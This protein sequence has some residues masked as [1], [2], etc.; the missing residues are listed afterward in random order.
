MG[1]HGLVRGPSAEAPRGRGREREVEGASADVRY[2]TTSRRRTC[3]KRI[4]PPAA[5]REV[6]VATLRDEG[7][8]D[9]PHG[10]GRSQDGPL[11]EPGR[12]AFHRAYQ[13]NAKRDL[14]GI[15][16]LDAH[17]LPNDT[18]FYEE[19]PERR[20][21]PPGGLDLASGGS[22]KGLVEKEVAIYI[23]MINGAYGTAIA[24][25]ALG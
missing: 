13:A 4:L 6:V 2:S 1:R 20:A 24:S 18:L 19:A 8:P 25:V 16:R 15:Q 21:P 5:K 11:G 23:T 10:Q 17:E 12:L 22:N 3:R 14:R 7:A 9:L